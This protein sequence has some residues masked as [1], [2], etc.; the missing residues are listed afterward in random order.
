MKSLAI[1]SQKGGVGKT[2]IAVNIACF[3]AKTGK[4]VM[5]LDCDFRGPSMMTFFKPKV[6]WL[7]EYLFNKNINMDYE[8]YLQDFSLDLNLPGKLLIGFAD[9]S[10]KA[11]DFVIRITNTDALIMLRKLLALRRE[12]RENPKYKVDYF[13]IDSSPGTGF[14]TVNAILATDNSLFLIK[15]SNADIIGT[16]NMIGGLYENLKAR[17][18]VLANQVPGSAIKDEDKKA[19][20]QKLIEDIFAKSIGEK[21]VEFLGWIPT[22]YT[23]QSIEFDEAVKVLRGE[24]S[25]RTIFTLKNPEHEFSKILT[26][27]IPSLFGT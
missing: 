5:L 14:E 6:K 24:E 26:E 21:V 10:A 9:P 27:I 12:L 22:D 16:S 13:I 1:L 18:L 19:E 23:F 4:N 11:I 25:A 3:L 17:S 15:L 8:E 20:I 2:S 7:N